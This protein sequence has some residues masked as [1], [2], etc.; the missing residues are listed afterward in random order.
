MYRWWIMW[1]IWYKEIEWMVFEITPPAEVKKPFRAM[2]DVI[3]SLW[4]LYDSP[5]WRE[6]WCQGEFPKGPFW[7]S[8]EIASFGGDIHFYVRLEKRL[9]DF[10]ES[11]LHAHY[12]DAEIREVPDYT[13][14]IPQNIP[15]D[16]WG[17]YGEDYHFRYDDPYPIRT[18]KFFEIKPEEV[19]EEKR[20]DPFPALLERMTKLKKDEQAWFQ[21]I[22]VPI[23]DRDVDWITQG[24]KLADKI[25]RRPEEEKPKSIIGETARALAYGKTPYEKEEKEEKEI[26]PPEMKLTPGERE[27]LQGI[28][29][30]ISK[31]GFKTSMRYLYI[32]RAGAYFS[33]YAKITRSYFMHFGTENLNSVLY[34]PRTRT[35][36]HFLFRKR[37]L[38]A[39]KRDMFRKYVKRFPPCYPRLIGYGTMIFNAE[40]LATMFHLPVKAA[41]LPPGV[42]RLLA[43]KGGPPP[44]IP[45]E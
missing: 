9:K 27:V 17:I 13:Q 1:E 12:P 36:V 18:Y 2:E 19:T 41:L 3:H 10:F 24:R 8:F 42:P 38:Y 35:R 40:E 21:M 25:A 16:K 11:V 34:L 32:H 33:P 29:E 14:N 15:N 28:E 23:L 43:K 31:H 6:E 5:N 20:L 39:R 30:K 22:L 26:I 44:G 4:P 37:R 45:T 7:L